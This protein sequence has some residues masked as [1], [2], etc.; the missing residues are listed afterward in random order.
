MLSVVQ[1]FLELL[2]VLRRVDADRRI[3]RHAHLATTARYI[4]TRP[5]EIAAAHALL[6]QVRKEPRRGPKRST[7]M[8]ST[9]PISLGSKGAL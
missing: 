6:E 2:G 5:D 3:L 9:A 8:A 1:P 7:M 4:H